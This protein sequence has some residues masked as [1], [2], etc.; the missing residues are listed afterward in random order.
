[1]DVSMAGQSTGHV[2][3]VD[4]IVVDPL[5]MSGVAVGNQDMAQVI[6]SNPAIRLTFDDNLVMSVEAEDEDVVCDHV[7]GESWCHDL[8]PPSARIGR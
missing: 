8:S 3:L 5:L 1:M 7:I 4:P 2:E 6:G